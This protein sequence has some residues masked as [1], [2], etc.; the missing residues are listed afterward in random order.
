MNAS[1][2]GG[3]FGNPLERA[4]DAVEQDLNLGYVSRASA[5]R[6]YGVVIAEAWPVGEHMRYRIDVAASEK[7]RQKAG[8][9]K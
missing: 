4:L 7:N 3:G 9:A 1:P 6:D 5:E 2:G 8:V